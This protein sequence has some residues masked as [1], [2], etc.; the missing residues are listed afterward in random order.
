MAKTLPVI[1]LALALMSVMGVAAQDSS[2]TLRVDVSMISVDV[3]VFNA[4][5]AC[6]ATVASIPSPFTA[7]PKLPEV[8]V[9]FANSFCWSVISC[10]SLRMAVN[11]A[12][13]LSTRLTSKRSSS[14]SATIGL[15]LLL[16]KLR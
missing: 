9:N 4:A 5:I 1:L 12:D 6:A 8:S 16:L 13:A 10:N 2:Y 11:P 7:L 3:A 14:N 15:L